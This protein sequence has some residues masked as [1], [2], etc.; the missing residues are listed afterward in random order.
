[1]WFFPSGHGWSMPLWGYYE[2]KTK[3]GWMAWLEEISGAPVAVL[4]ESDGTNLV[5]RPSEPQ[6][7]HVLAANGGRPIGS[8]YTFCLRPLALRTSQGW[9]EIGQFY[10]DRYE[11]TRPTGFVPQRAFREDLTELERAPSVFIDVD[12]SGTTHEPGDGK[13]GD[14]ASL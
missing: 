12:A 13:P 10:R 2:T 11:A 4:F 7:D 1:E 9:A 3:Q 6:P 14:L 8:T 5:W